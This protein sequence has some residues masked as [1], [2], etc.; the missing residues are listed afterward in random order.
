MQTFNV[1]KMVFFFS[2]VHPYHNVHPNNGV[3]SVRCVLYAKVAS[4]LKFWV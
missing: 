2:S 3:A 1:A 4:R